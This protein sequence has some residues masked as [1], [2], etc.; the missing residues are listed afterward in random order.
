[1]S[2]ADLA[3][4]HDHS[5]L[6]IEQTGLVRVRCDA[7]VAQRGTLDRV[8]VGDRATHHGVMRTARLHVLTDATQHVVGVA[9]EQGFE[10]RMPRPESIEQV[11]GDLARLF[12]CQRT[13]PLGDEFCL[14][15]HR[16]DALAGEEQLGDD[17]RHVVVELEACVPCEEGHCSS[18]P[19][20]C[21]CCQVLRAAR[22]DSAP[23]L[24]LRP[25]RSNP[26]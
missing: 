22:V 10:I 3:Q 8:L 13:Y 21:A 1:M 12:R 4:R 19:R 25:V 18:T 16:S 23:R 9:P 7:R 11:A 15:F 17:A 14:G 20:R 6:A 5:Q 2:L 26:S 24:S